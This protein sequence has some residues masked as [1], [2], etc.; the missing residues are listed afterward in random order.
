MDTRGNIRIPQEL[1]E[2]LA[3]EFNDGFEK[4]R[5]KMAAAGQPITI[6]SVP[7]DNEVPIDKLPDPNCK[8]CYGR[9]FIRVVL[10]NIREVRP[11]HCVQN[12]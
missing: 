5:Q 12:K 8:D 2:M 3:K 6:S 7:K 10:E 4:A 1:A 11:C 9:G